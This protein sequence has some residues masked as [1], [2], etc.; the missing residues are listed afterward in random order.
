MR[1]PN[2][3]RPRAGAVHRPAAPACIGA[4]RI[5]AGSTVSTVYMFQYAYLQW[6]RLET[7]DFRGFN[8]ARGWEV[9]IARCL[10]ENFV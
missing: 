3:Q 10:R 6:R 9:V 8:G 5:E 2:A 1:R 4:W 7:D